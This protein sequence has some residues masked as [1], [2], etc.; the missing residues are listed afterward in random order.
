GK[1]SSLEVAIDGQLPAASTDIFVEGY[2][3]AYF[4]KPG[5][6]ETPNAVSIFHLRID[7]LANV[8]ELRGRELTLTLTSGA[9]SLV[10]TIIVE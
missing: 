6:A 1:E 8:D 5:P 2:P 10:Q 9:E 7:G 4:R 3:K